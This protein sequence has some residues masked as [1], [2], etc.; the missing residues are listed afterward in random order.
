MP[1]PSGSWVRAHLF[2][3]IQDEE[4]QTTL[5][6]KPSASFPGGF[7][8]KAY[9]T[10]L[11]GVISA[12]YGAV[13]SNTCVLRGGIIYVNNG[14]YV[15]SKTI[16]TSVTGTV[17]Q[18]SLPGQ[19]AAVVR[20]HTATG[21][22][23]GRGRLFLPGVPETFATESRINATGVTAYEAFIAGLMAMPTQEDL[24]PSIDWQMFSRTDS[25]LRPVTYAD[26]NP[27][28]CHQRGRRPEF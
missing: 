1:L 28:L 26:L 21:G 5:W 18:D 14:S 17:V 6:F 10:E 2:F 20:L 19:D 15:A 22:R 16:T 23:K 27:I 3:R 12:L 8:I 4:A 13:M 7:D 24:S 25:T 9:T 11:Y